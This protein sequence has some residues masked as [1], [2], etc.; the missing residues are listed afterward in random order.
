VGKQARIKAERKARREARQQTQGPTV[1]RWAQIPDEAISGP[2][3]KPDCTLVHCTDPWS[4]TVK[5][6][7]KQYEGPL[8]LVCYGTFRE[9]GEGV[10]V[11]LRVNGEGLGVLPPA[12][13][14]YKDPASHQA[15]TQ[16]LGAELGRRFGAGATAAFVQ[17]LAQ[18]PQSLEAL[19]KQ[20]TP[21]AK[22]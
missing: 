15:V 18:S 20:Q 12:E 7:N 6:T 8:V 2:C 13:L 9:N 22:A 17:H 11:H 21:P 1:E 19:A 10:D 3:R 4:T 16:N 5:L 14:A